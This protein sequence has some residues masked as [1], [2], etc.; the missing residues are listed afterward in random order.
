VCRA[1]RAPSSDS[2]VA[3][4]DNPTVPQIAVVDHGTGNLT[5][6]IRAL[7]LA[8]AEA[9]RTADRNVIAAADA[10]VLPGVGAFPKA[11]DSIELLGL[12]GPIQ[13]FASSEKPLLGVC[14]GMQLLFDGS[15]EHGGAVGLGIIEG[16][17]VKL[18]AQGER[19]PHIGWTAVDWSRKHALNADLPDPTAMYHVHSFVAQPQVESDIL[20]TA[21]HGSEFVTAVAREHVVG[22][23]FH[24]EKS[25]RDGLG[26]ISNFVRWAAK[27][28]LA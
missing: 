24:P 26:M 16:S 27:G 8:G 11:I 4:S 14:L 25:S 13:E 20:A 2:P 10:L 12:T 7:S 17:V 1:P 5:S 15:E 6:L 23:Q 18:D 22:V 19:L 28:E 21:T 9:E 3:V